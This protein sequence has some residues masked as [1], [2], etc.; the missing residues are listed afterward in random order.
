MSVDPLKLDDR[1]MFY[2]K[3]KEQIEEWAALSKEVHAAADRFFASLVSAIE[4]RV[5]SR[6]GQVSVW[7]RTDDPKWPK[8]L[9]H[10]P[11]WCCSGK[12]ELIAG[13]G[14]EWERN[15]GFEKA[16]SG[17]WLNTGDEN[18]D[19]AEWLKNSIRDVGRVHKFKYQS[20]YWPAWRY[21]GGLV[22]DYWSAGRLEAF[23]TALLKRLDEEW[24]LFRRVVD[25]GVKKLRA[26]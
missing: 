25:D 21:T 4:E 8:I 24:E 12:D 19:A 13:I 9:C 14:L 3:N 22:G 7:A 15:A 26:E 2:L 18:V 17:V 10:L 6:H 20:N 5:T 16:Y 1:A 11:S 23:E